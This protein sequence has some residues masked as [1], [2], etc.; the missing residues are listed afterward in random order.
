[1]KD[2]SSKG[3]NVERNNEL[4]EGI[5]YLPTDPLA[6]DIPDD[7]LSDIV[8]KRIRDTRNFYK[9]DEY[10]LYTRREKLEM[11][12]FGRQIIQKEKDKL[13]KKYESR[14]LDNVLY[15]IESTI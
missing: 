13:L 7:E 6:L 2:E 5:A 4:G 12:R 1:M 3:D 14:Y 15:E 8:D 11:Y 10:D 9:S